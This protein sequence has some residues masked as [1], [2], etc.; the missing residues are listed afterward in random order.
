[1]LCA[2]LRLT[3]PRGR[4][5]RS[6]VAY[7]LLSF[8]GAYGCLYWALQ[9]V[10]AG[11]GAVVMAVGPLLTLLLAV[12]HRQEHLNA[13]GLAGALIALAGSVLIFFQPDE[14]SFGVAS[15]VILGLAALCASEAVV[16]SKSVGAQ[17]P[18][19]TNFVAHDGGRRRPDRRLGARGRDAWRSR[20]RARHSSRSSIS[21]RR[22]SG[23][24]SSC[25]SSSSAG[26]PRRRRTSSS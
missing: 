7:G 3:L 21:S 9:D 22:P 19:V 23:S 6:C 15:L 8:A 12:A 4:V 13:R 20:T 25:S 1:M 5:L 14:T 24:S 2:V 17:H 16:V 18:L 10:P 11:I 26:R